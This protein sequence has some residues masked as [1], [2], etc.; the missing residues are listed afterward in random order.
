MN[1]AAFEANWE[2][3]DRRRDEALAMLHRDLVDIES[4]LEKL[5]AWDMGRDGI[6]ASPSPPPSAAESCQHLNRTPPRLAGPDWCQDCHSFVGVPDS[7]QES[8]EAAT[9]G[10]SPSAQPTTI[11]LAVP[12]CGCAPS[13]WRLRPASVVGM[14]D[15]MCPGGALLVHDLIHVPDAA[16][17]PSEST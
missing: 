7:P 12:P 3:R 1:W 14:W 11:S 10:L 13:S 4:L 16:A 2:N 5:L 15:L 17:S 9:P 6:E 8:I